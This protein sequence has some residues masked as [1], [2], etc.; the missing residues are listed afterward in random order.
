MLSLLIPTLF[1][2]PPIVEHQILFHRLDVRIQW[3]FDCILRVS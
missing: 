2:N 3:S 1:E